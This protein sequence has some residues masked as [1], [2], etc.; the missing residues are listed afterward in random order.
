MKL[1]VLQAD[2]AAGLETGPERRLLPLVVK[3]DVQGSAEAV[4]Q[5]VEQMSSDQVRRSAG[6]PRAR[7]HL[8]SDASAT[9]RS[10]ARWTRAVCGF[11][12]C[13]AAVG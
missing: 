2:A 8:L 10:T 11:L 12:V 13:G 4:C 3:A 9:C 6:P 7:S 5:A 1:V